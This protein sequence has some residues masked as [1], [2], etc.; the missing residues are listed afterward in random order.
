MV[1]WLA[2]I[3]ILNALAAGIYLLWGLGRIKKEEE[4]KEFRTKYFL[5]AGVILFCPLVG[6]CFLGISWLFF[7]LFLQKQVDMADISFDRKKN[8]IYSVA[9]VERD[10]NMVP[11][12]EALLIGDVGKRRKMLLDV[13]KRDV[14]NSLGAIAIALSNPD[15]ET[16][17]YAASVIMDALSEFR[18]NVQ[19]M[20]AQLKKDPENTGLAALL[21]DYISRILSQKVLTGGEERAYTYTLSEVGDM[22]FQAAP[23]RMTGSQYRELIDALTQIQDYALGEKWARRAMEYRA[24]QLDSY[25]ACLKLYLSYRDREA[26]LRCLDRL[27][28]SGVVVD[29][30]TMELIRIFEN[31]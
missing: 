23:Y 29:N 9:D 4:P 8:K 22:L 21:L 13:L 12:Q 30:Q 28:K 24:D 26:F 17:H 14:R 27:K 10:I 11:M 7:R 2:V 19:N 16:S 15:T 18:G 5:L 31:P 25:V 6:L 3:L 1:I 20:L